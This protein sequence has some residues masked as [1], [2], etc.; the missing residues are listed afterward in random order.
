MFNES[1]LDNFLL[2]DQ[3]ELSYEE[4]YIARMEQPL[5]EM[6]ISFKP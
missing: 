2:N 6:R 5:K 3:E 4:G 1:D